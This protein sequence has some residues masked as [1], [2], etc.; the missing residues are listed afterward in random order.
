MN[1]IMKR[2]KQKV[3][4]EL[5]FKTYH[6]KASQWHGT[7]WIYTVAG[8]RHCHANDI[9]QVITEYAIMHQL[10]Q[11]KRII[12]R[13]NE[14]KPTKESDEEAGVHA[15]YSQISFVAIKTYFL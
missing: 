1:D 14:Y 7:H 3:L 6:L 2:L 4:K 12:H 11:R 9:N 13:N 8:S 10:L 15:I 5:D